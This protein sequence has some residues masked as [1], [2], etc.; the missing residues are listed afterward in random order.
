MPRVSEKVYIIVGLVCL[1]GH[2]FYF[3]LKVIIIF[4]LGACHVIVDCE[5]HFE[6]MVLYISC[7]VQQ[8]I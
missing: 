5:K 2:I 3:C 6:L 1:T 7:E 4:H 8:Y